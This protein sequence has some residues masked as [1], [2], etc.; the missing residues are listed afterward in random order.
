MTC[1]DMCL[2]YKAR[3]PPNTRR[4]SSGQKRCQICDIFINWEGIF[5]PCCGYRLRFKPRNKQWKQKL[6]DKVKRY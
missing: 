3:R 5:C 4:Y 6:L 2:Q 1:K